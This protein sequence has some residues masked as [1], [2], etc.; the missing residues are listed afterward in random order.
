MRPHVE[1]YAFADGRK[2]YLLGE[3]RLVNLAAGQGHPVE[4][5]DLSFALQALSAEHIAKHGRSMSRKVHAVPTELDREVARAALAPFGIQID[6]R[7]D[8]QRD[9]AASW[10]LGT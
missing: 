2:V 8:A 7:T 9:Y 4:I 3:G 1:E 10:E 5:M 6:E